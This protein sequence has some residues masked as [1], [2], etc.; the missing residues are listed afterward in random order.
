MTNDLKNFLEYDKKVFWKDAIN[1]TNPEDMVEGTFV[2]ASYNVLFQHDT[3]LINF[4]L[5]L[6]EKE[7]EKLCQKRAFSEDMYIKVKLVSTII[8]QLRV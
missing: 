7:V 8:N 4:V 3:R 2:T 5:D 6:V 1:K